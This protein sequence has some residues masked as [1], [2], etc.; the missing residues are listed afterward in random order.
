[1]LSDLEKLSYD[2]F[3]YI[4]EVGDI[5]RDELLNLCDSSP[6]FSEYCNRNDQLIFR[7]ALARIYN[8]TN[9]LDH[10]PREFLELFKF[11]TMNKFIDQMRNNNDQI[12]VEN[13]KVNFMIPD[14]IIEELAEELGV[15]FDIL[16]DTK[17][18]HEILKQH[19]ASDFVNNNHIEI[20]MNGGQDISLDA[21]IPYSVNDIPIIWEKEIEQCDVELSK[22]ELKRSKPGG[23]GNYIVNRNG[24]IIQIKDKLGIFTKDYSETSQIWRNSA[25]RYPSVQDALDESNSI[26]K[27]NFELQ[28]F[29]EMKDEDKT[30]T[31]V[32]L[33]I[34]TVSDQ[35]QR[36]KKELQERQYVLRLNGKGETTELY[37]LPRNSKDINDQ[38]NK[39]QIAHE[40]ET[41]IIFT[42]TPNTKGYLIGDDNCINSKGILIGFHLW[43]ESIARNRLDQRINGNQILR[44]NDEI[45]SLL[46]GNKKCI[47]FKTQWGTTRKIFYSLIET[48][49]VKD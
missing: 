7:K 19:I 48:P 1:M 40:G 4:I 37:Q 33:G 35:L 24:K 30:T 2:V 11:D 45:D 16:F 13:R 15:T 9:T 28:I 18:F 39:L 29:N 38:I 20:Y 12:I 42:A 6:I 47:V 8:I 27:Y 5:E 3:S 34:I 43:D 31:Y 36:L 21:N 23:Y 46:N 41:I 10:T 17:V 22:P 26:K 25:H 32:I 49:P 14:R 44:N